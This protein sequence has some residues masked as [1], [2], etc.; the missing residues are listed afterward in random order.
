[1]PNTGICNKF[2][3][4]VGIF[5]I[6]FLDVQY[7]Q[8]DVWYLSHDA[9]QQTV[10]IQTNSCVKWHLL[11]SVNISVRQDHFWSTSGHFNQMFCPY[12][13]Q[14][15]SEILLVDLGFCLLFN[16]KTL[17]NITFRPDMLKKTANTNHDKRLVSVQSWSNDP[18]SFGVFP[19]NQYIHN[20]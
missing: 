1:M 17:H 12:A 18:E 4:S 9:L 7:K 10:L 20:A 14:M 13:W 5:D 11:K 6:I 19:D 3:K 15:L 2:D 16:L 8:S